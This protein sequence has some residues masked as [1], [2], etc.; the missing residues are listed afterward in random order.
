MLK[1]KRQQIEIAALICLPLALAVYFICS[2]PFKET[3]ASRTIDLSRY[4]TNQRLNFLTAARALDGAVIK[5]GAVFSFNGRVGPRQSAKG[6]V[7]AP[8]YLAGRLT[9][10]TGGGICLVSSTLYQVALLSGLQI[11]E[12]T[13][14]TDT[15]TSV[16]PGLDATVWYGRADLKIKNPY[17]VPV[18]LSSHAEGDSLAIGIH[19]DALTKVSQDAAGRAFRRR[20]ISDGDKHTLLVEVYLKD[21]PAERLISRDRYRLSR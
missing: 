3:L 7:P 8:S 9:S 10:S 18:E 6:F 12:R 21:G 4:S 1:F 11:V 2:H 20:Q 19:A 17:A 16:A 13:P 5:P 15:V 14:H